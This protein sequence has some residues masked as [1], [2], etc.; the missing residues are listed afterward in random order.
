MQLKYVLKTDGD[1]PLSVEGSCSSQTDNI[2]KHRA[3]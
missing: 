2:L 3:N 1:L